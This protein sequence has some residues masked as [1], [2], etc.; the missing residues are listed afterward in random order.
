MKTSGILGILCLILSGGA[1]GETGPGVFIQSIQPY[2]KDEAVRIV[3]NGEQMV[4][5]T[6]W[7]LE[8]SNSLGQEVK[9]TFWFPRGCL[10]PAGGILTIHSGPH[11]RSWGDRSCGHH[12]IDLPWMEVAIWNDQADVAWLRD[13]AGELIDLYTYT[14]KAPT[15][16][17]PSP[18]LKPRSERFISEPESW[19]ERYC[20]PRVS[21]DGRCCAV[22][23]AL[24]SIE[25]VYN[26]CVGENWRFFAIAG[27]L[28]PPVFQEHLPQVIYEDRFRGE[29]FLEV[30]AGAVEEDRRPDRGWAS[31]TVRL[32][33][34]PGCRTEWTISVEVP[35]RE[36]EACCA[37]CAAK[38][39]FHFQVVV[40]PALAPVQE[41]RIPPSADFSVSPPRERL[42]GDTV[43][44]DGSPSAGEELRFAWD[45]DGDGRADARGKQTSHR[46]A[47]Q[48]MNLITLTVTDRWGRSDSITRGVRAL[49]EIDEN[50]AELGL[51]W[52]T[53]PALAVGYFLVLAFR[54]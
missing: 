32:C 3:K 21:S 54:G 37:G 14:G 10:L 41:E 4:D 9:E 33:C 31:R 44:L 12:E 30:G 26:E 8:S 42:V 28:D 40:A 2:G 34:P 38:W 47:R 5:L 11:A 27:P 7:R 1:L 24:V 45:F 36:N 25:P 18:H 39:R 46:L 13:S 15:V 20:R 51:F 19:A 53:L 48:G 17:R 49:L 35:V 6:G 16:P 23:V 52:L 43:S 22:K 50:K 29:L